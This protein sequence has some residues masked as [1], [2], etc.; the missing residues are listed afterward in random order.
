M[1]AVNW[2]RIRKSDDKMCKY[3]KHE[4]DLMLMDTNEHISTQWYVLSDKDD[5]REAKEEILQKVCKTQ[6]INAAHALTTSNSLL[7]KFI[8]N[9]ISNTLGQFKVSPARRHPEN[10][11]LHP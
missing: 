9:H 4:H 5:I 8:A 10:P 6:G 7:T 2:Y 11:G 3:C 1:T